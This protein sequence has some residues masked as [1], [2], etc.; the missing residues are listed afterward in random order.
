MKPTLRRVAQLLT[1]RGNAPS[2]LGGGGLRLLASV[3]S[4]EA[5]GEGVT[6]ASFATVVL[7]PRVTPLPRFSKFATLTNVEFHAKRL[8]ML[9]QPGER[10]HRPLIHLRRKMP[11]ADVIHAKR[12]E[13]PQRRG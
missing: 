2:P 4:L 8:H 11:A 5:K 9:T 1:K 12:R 3:A 7:T 10:L 13:G 6:L